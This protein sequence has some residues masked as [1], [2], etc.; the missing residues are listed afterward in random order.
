[1]PSW[2]ARH[3]ISAVYSAFIGQLRHTDASGSEQEQELRSGRGGHGAATG[4]P[5]NKVMRGVH[6]FLVIR[7]Q[8]SITQAP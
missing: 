1:M 5:H 8:A 6:G 7:L 4:K 2:H 3:A